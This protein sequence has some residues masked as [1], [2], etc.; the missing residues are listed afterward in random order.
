MIAIWN[1]LYASIAA[2]FGENKGNRGLQAQA[3][4]LLDIAESSVRFV[5]EIWI[6]EKGC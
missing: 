5:E 3:P 4:M 6:E 2:S 1:K